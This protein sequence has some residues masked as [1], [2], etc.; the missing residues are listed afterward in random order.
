[1]LSRGFYD[2]LSIWPTVV[3]PILFS[4]SFWAFLRLCLA[5]HRISDVPPL[6]ARRGGTAV[7]WTFVPAAALFEAAIHL[8]LLSVIGAGYL[9]LV[10]F[11]YIVGWTVLPILLEESGSAL[12]LLPGAYLCF[13]A[14]FLVLI[15]A[16][17]IGVLRAV[18]SQIYALLTGVP[19][20]L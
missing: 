18:N 20:A 15:G 2:T 1:M 7:F 6:T 3:W 16:A 10:P 9:L 8:Y 11:I 17:D 19:V 4:S 14:A 12:V 13:A 5:C